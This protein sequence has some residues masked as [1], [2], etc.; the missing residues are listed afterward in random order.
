[1]RRGSAF[2]AD[3]KPFYEVPAGIS[4]E[5]LWDADHA[6]NGRFIEVVRYADTPTYLRDND[7]VATDPTMAAYL[8]RWRALLIEPV[9]VERYEDL[10]PLLAGGPQ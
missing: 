8:R 9:A 2:L 5:L 10:T 3:A 6:D 1:M 4:V 7:R